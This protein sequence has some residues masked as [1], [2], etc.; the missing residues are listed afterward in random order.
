MIKKI[1]NHW[2]REIRLFKWQLN[3]IV[4]VGFV[5]GFGCGSWVTLEG[6]PRVFAD[7]SAAGSYTW[8][9]DSA[10][11]YSLSSSTLGEIAANK[12]RFKVRNYTSDA[13]TKWLAHLDE[14]SGTAVDDVSSSNIDGTLTLP[15]PT[16]TTTWLAGKL[17][18][19]NGSYGGLGLDG[20]G[21]YV[22]VP[23]TGDAVTLSTN[24]LLY[25]SRCV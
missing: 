16:P 4:L 13:S 12:F 19:N 20:N 22:A 25:T 14:T 21:S 11:E 10:G 8:T 2:K 1:I 24:C 17:D 18:G 5:L 23:D 7:T 3:L 9:F 6:A 15:V